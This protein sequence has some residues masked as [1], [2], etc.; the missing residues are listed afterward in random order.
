MESDLLM[1]ITFTLSQSFLILR[2][3]FSSHG[4]LFPSDR[5]LQSW[6]LYQHRLSLFVCDMF[7]LD[8]KSRSID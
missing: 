1:S 3:P 6:S 5:R 7:L 2:E 8:G 4:N